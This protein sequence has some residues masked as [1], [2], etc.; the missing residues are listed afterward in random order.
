MK[1]V[2]L[3]ESNNGTHFS[4]IMQT[5]NVNYSFL[6][7]ED[8][9]HY[10]E[11]FDR[12]KCRDI[13][14]HPLPAAMWGD[15][16]VGRVYGLEMEEAIDLDQVKMSIQVPHPDLLIKGLRVIRNLEKEFE[17][18]TE[19]AELYST[20][21]SD[22]FVITA[23]KAWFKCMVTFSMI[24]HL[25]RATQYSSPKAH[26]KFEQLWKNIPLDSKD[27]YHIRSVTDNKFDIRFFFS[28]I[29]KILENQ[30]ATGFC[31]TRLI[32][33]HVGGG[34]RVDGMIMDH[35][36]IVAFSGEI[37]RLREGRSESTFLGRTWARKYLELKEK[38]VFNYTIREGDKVLIDDIEHLVLIVHDNRVR[39]ESSR[40]GHIFNATHYQ[41][42]KV[43]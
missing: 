33:Q 17:D 37:N 39:V 6:K 8:D 35:S 38:K 24:T 15:G 16:Q 27:G 23:D 18:L 12:V 1:S 32:G 13:L 42:Q 20:S 25:I 5:R 31:D 43:I 40:N 11:M 22:V 36:G 19:R 41:C 14:Q 9:G 34:S 30:P 7:Q 21:R 4:Q 28:H 2:E 29:D 3:L 10:V 26:Y